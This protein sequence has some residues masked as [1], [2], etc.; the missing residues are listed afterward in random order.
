[1]SEVDTRIFCRSL[2]LNG[3]KESSQQKVSLVNTARAL[4][5]PSVLQYWRTKACDLRFQK[6]VGRKISER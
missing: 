5:F 6:P 2:L 1:M 4:A 3:R